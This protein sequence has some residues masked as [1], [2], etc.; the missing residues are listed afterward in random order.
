MKLSPQ[1]SDFQ[2]K[3]RDTIAVFIICIVISIVFLPR[4]IPFGKGAE[5]Y[6]LASS[7]AQHGTFANPYQV[8]PTGQSAANPPFYPFILAIFM[9]LF[10][11]HFLVALA[12]I[13]TNI[14]ANSFVAA[15]LLRV[16][17]V[18]YRDIRPG[19]FAAAFWIASVELL[20]SWD[21]A[22]TVA[23]LLL[24]ITYTA[25]TIGEPRRRAAPWIAGLI[26]AA[27]FLL[28][29]SAI[30]IYLPWFAFLLLSRAVPMRQALRY[31]VIASLVLAFAGFGWA[32]RNRFVLGAFVVRTNLGSSLYVSNNDCAQP[33][34]LENIRS[35]CDAPHNPNGS[36][37][38]AR[39]IV[40][41]GEVAHDHLRRADA[42]AWMHAH[43]HAFLRL[44]LV[45]ILYFWF[46]PYE[47]HPFKMGAIWLATAL[48]IPGLIWMAVERKQVTLFI[49]AV[50][51][52]YPFM[53]YVVVSEVRYRYPVLWLTLLPAGYLLRNLLPAAPQDTT[54]VL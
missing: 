50:F 3:R 32:L 19:I 23:L 1:T 15:W 36:L 47:F 24:F 49:V 44:T 27:L 22:Y 33:S 11:T 35:G 26:A 20:P 30:L 25:Q 43:P 37:D 38:D 45:R 34:L 7:L 39:Q 13:S 6:A 31:T 48:S 40:A 9:R 52:I 42:F 5:T 29:P 12:A 10:K 54:T 16:S 28:N 14:L 46:P 8:M 2:M 41:M 18:F 53:Y 51:L 21:V 17:V 4:F